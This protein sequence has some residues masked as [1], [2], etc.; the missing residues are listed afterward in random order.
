MPVASMVIEAGHA[1]HSGSVASRVRIALIDRPQVADKILRPWRD[2][3]VQQ[4]HRAPEL[5]A[6]RVERYVGIVG[7]ERVIA[8]TDCRAWLE[9]DAVG[10]GRLAQAVESRPSE[11]VICC[12][13]S[14]TSSVR[15]R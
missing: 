2:R 14:K 7:T 9:G 13:V 10:A 8:G 11:R 15:R 4:L 1:R 12:D 3:H 6:R 5:I